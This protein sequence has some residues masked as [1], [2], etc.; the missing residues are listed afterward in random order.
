MP[1]PQTGGTHYHAHL[2]L[3]DKGRAIQGFVVCYVVWLESML[4][5]LGL[6][7]SA[8]CVGLVACCGQGGYK[9]TLHKYTCRN[10]K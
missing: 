1:W 9:A 3:P 6:W 7:T 2:G 5:G 10:N 4:Y 8:R